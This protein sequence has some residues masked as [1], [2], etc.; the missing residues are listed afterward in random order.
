M[1][2]NNPAQ[3]P[4]RVHFLPQLLPITAELDGR[5][6]FVTSLDD[7]FEI[8]IRN[9]SNRKI[10]T[11]TRRWEMYTILRNPVTRVETLFNVTD[12][13]SAELVRLRILRFWTNKY[14][15]LQD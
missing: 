10:L 12:P 1:D 9:S 6:P 7:E 2:P 15:E 11:L 13:Y 5:E 14:F 3:S 8:L 4:H